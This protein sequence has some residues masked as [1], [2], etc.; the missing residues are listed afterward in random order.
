VVLGDD[1]GRDEM[2][3]DGA[4][5]VGECWRVGLAAFGVMLCSRCAAGVESGARRGA[6][7]RGAPS[8]RHSPNAPRST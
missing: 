1:P 4:L 7:A 2:A 6:V 5:F 3:D 8:S